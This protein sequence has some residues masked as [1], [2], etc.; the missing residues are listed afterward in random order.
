M[1]NERNRNIQTHETT[2]RIN[3]NMNR[4]MMKICRDLNDSNDM[5]YYLIYKEACDTYAVIG[6]PCNYLYQNDAAQFFG[7][8]LYVS[9]N[10][11]SDIMQNEFTIHK[12]VF[13]IPMISTA[14]KTVGDKII[15]LN[16]RQIREL[17]LNHKIDTDPGF[18][19]AF[20]SAY[21][22]FD[23][24]D[25]IKIIEPRSSMKALYEEKE[26]FRRFVDGITELF[27]IRMN[28]LGIAGSAA[29]HT[30]HP[31]DYDIVFYGNADELRR[32]NNIV[33]DI[34]K[35]QGV[36]TAMGMPLPFSFLYKGHIVDTFYVYDDSRIK[37]L[38]SAEIRKKNIQ[39]ACK[40]TDDRYA[41][42]V[43][44]F[45]GVNADGFSYLIIAETFFHAVIRSGDTIEGYGD[46]LEW[47][48]N[49]KTVNV[50]LCREPFEQ[51]KEFT[52]YFYR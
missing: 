16:S 39:F 24:K 32:I 17:P 34:N 23:C 25:V 9:E 26:E 22:C 5:L 51:I 36:P 6:A 27:G 37:N 44:P 3:I 47:N 35:I 30:D 18:L 8:C 41:L 21:T 29:L 45:F 42:Q 52:R 4:N 31:K 2:Y 11:I 50:M 15:S 46:I 19:P 38:Y 10:N 1:R 48:N 43:E 40:V 13:G 12:D 14:K 33:M 28:Q 7:T 49:G 20:Y